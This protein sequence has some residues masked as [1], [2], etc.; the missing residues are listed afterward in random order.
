MGLPCKHELQEFLFAKE[1]LKRDHLHPHWWLDPLV[2]ARPVDPLT[3]V[4]NPIQVR[5][6]GRPIET[7]TRR[8]LSQWELALNQVSQREQRER[9]QEEQRE[10]EEQREEEGLASQATGQRGGRGRSRGRG[11]GGRQRARAA[12][13]PQAEASGQRM[14]R[15]TSQQAQQREETNQGQTTLSQFTDFAPVADRLGNM[16]QRGQQGPA[17][18]GTSGIPHE[19][20]DVWDI[21]D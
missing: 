20:L 6:R 13:P 14:T 1:S 15:V 21:L 2:D 19:M 8:D 3:V 5:R 10:A 4:Q 11:R 7:S 12:H 16:R 17:V 18:T 9:E